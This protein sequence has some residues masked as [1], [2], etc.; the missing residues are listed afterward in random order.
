MNKT[1]RFIFK[2]Y[3]EVFLTESLTENSRLNQGELMNIQSRSI[4]RCNA[5][6]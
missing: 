4:T 5:S 6:D 2:K 3:V 1:F